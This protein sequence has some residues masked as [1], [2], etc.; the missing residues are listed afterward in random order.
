MLGARAAL[1]PARAATAPDQSCA[2]LLDPGARVAQRRAGGRAR[3]GTGRAS[4]VRLARR[5]LSPARDAVRG[6]GRGGRRDP[7][8]RM[9]VRIDASSRSPPEDGR[10]VSRAVGARPRP[11]G[12]RGRGQR[13]RAAPRPRRDAAFGSWTSRGS[14]GRTRPSRPSPR[15]SFRDRPRAVRDRRS[16]AG[17]PT[18]MSGVILV[19]PCRGARAGADEPVRWPAGPARAV[20]HRPAPGRLGTRLHARRGPGR[21]PLRRAT[22]RW[23]SPLWS[24]AR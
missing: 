4:S 15:P 1:E 22:R 7:R 24:R 13:H 20:V 18:A 8:R 11:A 6:A 14:T 10:A 3:P 17:S 2:L 21:V 5:R 12:G 16:A 23:P 19:N 9:L